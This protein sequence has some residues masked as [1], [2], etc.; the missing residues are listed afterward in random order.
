MFT[1]D[2]LFWFCAL[3]GSGMFLIQT[4]LYFS[5]A[6]A[7][8][9]S[10]SQ[11]FKWLSKQAVT[12]FLMMFG[13]VGLACKKELALTP[14]VSTLSAIAAGIGA[15]TINALIFN[16]ARKLRSTGTVFHLQD[17][18]GKEASVYQKIP[19]DGSGKISIS[20]HDMTHEID[21]ISLN[22]E[23]ISSFTQVVIPIK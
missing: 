4:L 2:G 16:L 10:S 20:L 3:A 21:A 12:G 11:N 23:E 5:G 13:W 17:A 18:L 19:K 7:E 14:L 6:D 9:D 22:G 8:D 15:M 1:K